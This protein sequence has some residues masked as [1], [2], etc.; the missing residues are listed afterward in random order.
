M[1]RS[2]KDAWLRDEIILALD[3]YQREGRNPS[4]EAT[5]STG[6]E[7]RSIPVEAHL[8]DDPQFRNAAAVNSRS[9]TSL[10]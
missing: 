4:A 6:Q 9:P 3:L 1:S 5:E 10:R 2:R 7:L 8:A